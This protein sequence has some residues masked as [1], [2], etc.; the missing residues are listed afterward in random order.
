M[1]GKCAPGYTVEDKTHL[2][3]IR[4]K[5]NNVKIQKGP[6]GSKKK[7]A[8][9]IGTVRHLVRKFEIAECAKKHLTQLR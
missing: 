4:Y 7:Y 6:H 5:E 8:I 9:Q 3:W 1:L 2:Q